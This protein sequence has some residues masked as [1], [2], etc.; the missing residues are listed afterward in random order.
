MSVIFL[1]TASSDVSAARTTKVGPVAAGLILPDWD[2]SKSH[3]GEQPTMNMNILARPIVLRSTGPHRNIPHVFRGQRRHIHESVTPEKPLF[4]W[5]VRIIS[6]IVV[7]RRI[8]NGEI[9]TSL[10]PFGT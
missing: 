1:V 8:L 5:E 7:G 4:R 6:D 9:S 3:R 2:G 10:G